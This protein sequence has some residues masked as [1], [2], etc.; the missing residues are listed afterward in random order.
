MDTKNLTVG[1][2]V[3]M[4]S[5]ICTSIGRVVAVTSD[6]VDVQEYDHRSISGWQLSGELIHFGRDGIACDGKGTFE[7]GY[8]ELDSIPFEERK[9]L[10][11][12]G[13]GMTK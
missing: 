10:F 12:Q 13:L 11:E 4:R 9:A 6:G 8:W 3:Y 1:Q 5:G 2:D 7:C